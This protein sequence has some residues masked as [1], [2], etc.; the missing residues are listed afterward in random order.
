MRAADAAAIAQL[1]E[2]VL[3]AN[4]GARI[5]GHLREMAEPGARIVAFAGPGNNGGDAFAALALLAPDYDCTIAADP[6]GAPFGG[7]P[8]CGAAREGSRRSRRSPAER[9]GARASP[10]AGRRRRRWSVRYRRASAVT[11]AIPAAFARARPAL[12]PGARDRH[13]QRNRRTNRC[14]KRRCRPGERNGN[15]GRGEA[16]IAAGAGTAKR[17]RALVRGYRHRRCYPRRAAPAVCGTRRRGVHAT[18]AA[19]SARHREANCRGSTDCRGIVRSS[20]E[21]QCSARV[22]PL[23][24]GPA[25]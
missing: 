15:A 22:A 20:P 23:A 6:D 18:A 4:A 9:R 25:M 12:R 24:P 19:A 3:M 2:D 11:P 8:R 21:R 14:G 7:A 13:P 17:R 1:G 10:A 16:R 5:A